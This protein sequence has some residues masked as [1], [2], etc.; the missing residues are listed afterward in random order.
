MKSIGFKGSLIASVLMLLALS[1]IVSNALSYKQLRDTTIETIDTRSLTN[2]NYEAEILSQW[3]A[4]RS[5]AIESLAVNYLA[6]HSAEHYVLLAEITQAG[7]GIDEVMFSN[8]DNQSFST[9]E[10]DN[11]DNGVAYPDLFDGTTRPWYQLGKAS[12]VLDVTE[13]YLDAN[14]NLPVISVVKSVE[15]GVILGDIYLGV[16]DDAVK[17]I[18]FPGA[19]AVIFDDS[20]TVLATDD[21]NLTVGEKL[22]EL[23]MSTQWNQIH[24][25]G[26]QRLEYVQHGVERLAYVK[27]VEL[28]NDKRWHLMVE[29]DKRIAYAELDTALTSAIISSLIMLAI[30]CLLVLVVLNRMFQPI[31]RLKAMVQELAQGEGDLTKRLPISSNDDI[32]QISESINQVVANMQQL[33]AEV[34]QASDHITASID[35]VKRQALDTNDGLQAHSAE[36]HQIVAAIEEM[37]ATAQDVARNAAEASQF[38][39]RTNQKTQNS[40]AMIIDT[41]KTVTRLVGEVDSTASSIATINSDT[42]EITHVLKVIGDIADQT[43]LLALNAAIEAARAG[44]Q[45]RGFAVV[46]DEVRALAGRT[47]KSTAEVEATLA[48]LQHGSETSI[49]AMAV[50]KGTCENTSVSTAAVV[51]ELDSI[52]ESVVQ[53]NDLNSQIA[54]AAEE[55]SSVALE[56]SRNMN[57]IQDIVA[58]L[59]QNGQQAATE[60]TNLAAI[61]DK[62]KE[63]IGRFKLS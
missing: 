50:A 58:N 46:A 17:S 12:G 33:M 10:G 63:V 40:Q 55:Q 60:A 36:T 5:K 1:L 48:K 30:G 35:Q 54:T 53:L 31:L 59:S 4:R 37:N 56:L 19:M 21:P 47:Q 39:E 14:T 25:E 23:G 43:N 15:D 9:Y 34:V 51:E 38:T 26:Q 13:V 16:L 45:G 61:N 11:W 62:L 20:G 28:V 7:A 52:V 42:V 27:P 57:S 18:D 2:V 24:N 49:S 6:G 32:G 44:D 29:V 41:A 3:F 8:E 22:S